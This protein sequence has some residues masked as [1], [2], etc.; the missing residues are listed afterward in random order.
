MQLFL[1]E[2]QC[3][4]TSQLEQLKCEVGRALFLPDPIHKEWNGQLSS[5]LYT[6]LLR[7]PDHTT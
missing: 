2:L 6:I 3:F 7:S 1:G 4:S 5:N